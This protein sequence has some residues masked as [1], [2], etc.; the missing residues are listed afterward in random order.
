M[1]SL[2]YLLDDYSTSEVALLLVALQYAVLGPAWVVASLVL[3]VERRTAGWW[4]AYACGSALGLLLLVIAMHVGH[5]PMRALGNVVVLAATL[6]LQRGL[7]LFAGQRCWTALQLT[8]LATII[9]LNWLALDPSWVWARI[10]F[11]SALWG[12]IYLWSAFDIWRHVRLNMQQRWGLLYATLLL[13]GGLM[14]SVRGVRGLVAPESV[15]YEVEQ[16]TVLSVGSSL[17]GLVASLML[18]MMLVS[19][20]V[21]RLVGRLEKLSRHDHVTGLLNRGA[22]VELL[23]QEVQRVR[24]L[25]GLGSGQA[26]AQGVGQG[27]GQMAV[28][29]IDIDYFKQINDGHGHDAG[30]RALQH[31]A[32]VMGTQLRE[33]DHLARWGGDEF[34]ALLPDSSLDD[35]RVLA[36]RLCD[37]VR[38]LALVIDGE[39]LPLT[40]S[41]GAAD[42]LGPQDNVLAL[43]N[44]ADINLYQGKDDGRG[45]VGPQ[46]PPAGPRR[47]AALKSV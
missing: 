38:E 45:R 8:V 44:R 17:T 11:G 1:E 19:L 22:M 43:L 10:A 46:E 6:A 9:G 42:W 18:Q 28:L 25:A 3:P 29:M 7:W 34:L 16:N 36:Q 39:R 32:A 30:D 14:L 26:S 33:V 37:R 4:A 40:V 23:N 5:A 35:A 12:A 24:R 27:A 13:L 47:A 21:S 20:L 31:L 15:I 41:I 2:A